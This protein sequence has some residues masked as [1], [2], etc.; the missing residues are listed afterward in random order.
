MFRPASDDAMAPSVPKPYPSMGRGLP[1]PEG[2]YG[3]RPRRSYHDD[4]KDDE[5][6]EKPAYTLTDKGFQFGDNSK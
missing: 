4:N 6:D 3:R 2:R 5:K 1:P